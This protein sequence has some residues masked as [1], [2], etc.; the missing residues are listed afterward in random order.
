[1]ETN[2]YYVLRVSGR[3]VQHFLFETLGKEALGRRDFIL[4]WFQL[5][6]LAKNAEIAKDNNLYFALR[7]LDSCF[8]AL[9]S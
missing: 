8:L 7:V 6:V 9:V 4:G 2:A 5:L 3:M 1:M